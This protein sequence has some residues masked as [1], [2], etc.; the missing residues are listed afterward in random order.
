MLGS[1]A[2][3]S[4]ETPRLPMLGGTNMRGHGGGGFKPLMTRRGAFRDRSDSS[5]LRDRATMRVWNEVAKTAV[6]GTSLYQ[7]CEDEF[8]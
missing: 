7:L 2:P 4:A 1:G 5:M 8:L 6:V 3:A